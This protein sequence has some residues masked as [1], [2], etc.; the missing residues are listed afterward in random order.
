MQGT[1]IWWPLMVCCWC[2]I[3]SEVASYRWFRSSGLLHWVVV[4]FIPDVSKEYVVFMSTGQWVMEIHFSG[5]PWPLKMGGTAFF[6]SAMNYLFTYS[7][8]Q[9][10]SWEANKISASQEIPRILW[11]L[12]VHYHIQKCPPPVPIPNHVDPVRALTSHFLKIHL[13]VIFPSTPGSSKWPL[14]RRFPHH[15]PVYTSTLPHT[16]YMPCPPNSSRFDHLNSIGWGVQIIKLSVQL[17]N[18]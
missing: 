2:W 3:L 17:L 10:N 6:K 14:S 11:N 9:S 1:K 18:Y 13:N 16:C 12:K 8:E 15:N 5:T 4:L 7:I